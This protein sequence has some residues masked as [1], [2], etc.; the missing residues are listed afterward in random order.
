LISGYQRQRIADR[1]WSLKPG[2]LWFGRRGSN[3][4]PA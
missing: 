2:S 3:G 1:N 4:L